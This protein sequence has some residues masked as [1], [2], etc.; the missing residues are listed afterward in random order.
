VCAKKKIIPHGKKLYYL[1][2]C[3][4]VRRI[5]I[6]LTRHACNQIPVEPEMH[7]KKPSQ[8]QRS[9]VVSDPN[10]NPNWAL[11]ACVSTFYT[12]HQNHASQAATTIR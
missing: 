7:P 9:T 5:N 10:P 8:S 12:A 11:G 2:L 1:L 6:R 3:L 4:T